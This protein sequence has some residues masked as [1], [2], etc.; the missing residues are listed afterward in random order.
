ML[1]DGYGRRIAAKRRIGPGQS[2]ELLEDLLL[3]IESLGCCLDDQVHLVPGNGIK[4]LVTPEIPAIRACAKLSHGG[5]KACLKRL[6]HRIG[7]IDDMRP[8]A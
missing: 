7:R 6:A 3:D 1:T 2:L 8:P 5:A 4:A